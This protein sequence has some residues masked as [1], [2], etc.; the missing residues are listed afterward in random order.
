MR[1]MSQHNHFLVASLC[2]LGGTLMF[3][4]P[5]ILRTS[6]VNLFS[7]TLDFLWV[8][9]STVFTQ[10]PLDTREKMTGSQRQRGLYMNNG[11]HGY[12]LLCFIDLYRS[13]IEH[14]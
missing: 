1:R 7:N 8:I 10:T 2:V 6:M 14:E 13:H 4:V 9:Q 3:S 12:M 5:Y 11:S